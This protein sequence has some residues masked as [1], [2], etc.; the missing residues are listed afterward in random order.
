MEYTTLAEANAVR[1][2]EWDTDN[3][4]TLAFRGNELAGE[5]GEACNIIKKLE[6]ERMGIRGSR[7]TKQQLLDELS[8][9]VIC[10]Y[11][12]AMDIGG[13]LDDAVRR[14]FNETSEKMGLQ[15]RLVAP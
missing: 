13:D 11:L 15:T 7:A 3:Q 4:I 14:K 1:Q 9:V 8:D 5:V 12:V 10:A 2:K 6:R